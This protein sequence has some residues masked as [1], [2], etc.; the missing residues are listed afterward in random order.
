MNRLNYWEISSKAA[1]AL[2]SFQNVVNTLEIDKKLAHLVKIRVSQ[3]NGCMFCLDM[4]VKE[5]RKHEERELRLYHLSAWRESPLFNDKER[6]A[7]EWTE[8]LTKIGTHGVEDQDYQKALQHFSEKE[9]SDLTF[10]ITII[11]AWNRLGV[12]FRPTPGAMDKMLGLD[13]LGLN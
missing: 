10:A 1:Q 11:N 9:L 8:L 5:A 6:A 3:I 7:L 4:H 13:K 12:A 2:M